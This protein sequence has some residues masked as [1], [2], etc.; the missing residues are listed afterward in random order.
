[1]SDF[2]PA[3]YTLIETIL[4]RHLGVTDPDV[5]RA[6]MR[7]YADFRS[8]QSYKVME[9]GTLAIA[10]GGAEREVDGAGER[11]AGAALVYDAV[12]TSSGTGDT[13]SRIL[14]VGDDG[15]LRHAHVRSNGR[16]NET[17]SPP[18][19]SEGPIQ[20]RVRGAPDLSAFTRASSRLADNAA[21]GALRAIVEALQEADPEK[22]GLNSRHVTL[23]G[24]MS[25]GMYDRKSLA[26]EGEDA[27]VV[28]RLWRAST[29]T[30][31]VNRGFERR[32]LA[33]TL[34]RFCDHLDQ[35]ALKLMRRVG[36]ASPTDYNWTLGDG[37]AD[38]RRNRAQAVTL[39][40]LFAEAIRRDK[41]VSGGVDA[42]LSVPQLLAT[43]LMVPVSTIE[44]LKGVGWQ[45]LGGKEA[46]RK[47]RA[48]DPLGQM[49]QFLA[50]VGA[51]PKEWLPKTR[52]GW[53]AFVAVARNVD[54][55]HNIVD[56]GMEPGLHASRGTPGWARRMR[57]CGPDWEK[58]LRM[59]AENPAQGV[60][61]M[62]NSLLRRIAVPVL[63]RRASNQGFDLSRTHAVEFAIGFPGIGEE[64]KGVK[65]DIL[66]AVAGTR[67]VPA[68]MADAA[69]WHANRGRLNR[70]T[71]H[72]DSR[73][74]DLSWKTLTDDYQARNGLRIRLLGSEKDLVNEGARMNHCVDGY[75]ENCLEG[76]IVGAVEDSK[77]RP[78]ATFEMKGEDKRSLRL[79][80]LFGPCNSDPGPKASV[81][82]KAYMDD[83]AS[84]R[85]EARFE[86]LAASRE[87]VLDKLGLTEH[88]RVMRLAGYDPLDDGRYAKAVSSYA[89]FLS[90]PFQKGD[91]DQI[92]DRLG[93]SGQADSYLEQIKTLHGRAV[94]YA[95]DEGRM[96]DLR[97]IGWESRVKEMGGDGTPSLSQL[98]AVLYYFEAASERRENEVRREQTRAARPSGETMD[99]GS[100]LGVLASAAT[101]Q[102]RENGR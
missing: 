43:G 97:Q 87:A 47:T 101:E 71:V 93:L 12:K 76:S 100:L 74:L 24:Q 17:D 61:D 58:S 9:P 64:N 56:L 77:G 30:Y 26:H 19:L 54:D 79:V 81:A 5:T 94:E 28:R 3:R 68:I 35:D 96:N 10:G 69:S 46:I 80:Q 72:F 66:K 32:R 50:A 2:D 25:E 20:R 6:A 62:A 53:K 42:G 89:R 88:D 98:K 90:K 52:K 16:I 83:I 70:E 14:Y 27:D 29:T 51:V 92:V 73:G 21:S 44:R 23:L 1:M 8:R 15:L 55:F 34:K 99:F 57:E 78:V 38:K 59:F 18:D 60:D 41:A 82:V 33:W 36:W 86:A 95:T 49:K 67:S 39:Y 40:P 63:A 7:N 85:I 37:D 31:A 65:P 48:A 75:L 4:T 13:N 91:P 45:K 11:K 84:G 22:T 102:T